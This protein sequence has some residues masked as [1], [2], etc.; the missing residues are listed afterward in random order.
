MLYAGYTQR[1]SIQALAEFIRSGGTL[2]KID[3]GSPQER[4]KNYR[5]VIEKEIRKLVRRSSSYNWD[6]MS[7]RRGGLVF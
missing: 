7:E 3:K 1:M 5:E 4:E 6:D 2:N